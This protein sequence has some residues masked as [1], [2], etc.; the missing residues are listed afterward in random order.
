MV[1]SVVSNKN[2]KYLLIEKCSNYYNTHIAKYG[3]L[4]GNNYADIYHLLI[5][6]DYILMSKELCTN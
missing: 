6:G 4:V 5:S 3:S 2:V 1:C